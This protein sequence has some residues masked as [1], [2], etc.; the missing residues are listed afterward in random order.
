MESMRTL[1]RALDI[2]E[3][4]TAENNHKQGLASLVKATELPKATVHRMVKNLERRGYLAYDKESETYRLGYRVLLLSTAYL[5]NLEIRSVALPYMKELRDQ[6]SESVS[7]WIEKNDL[8]VCVER[9]QSEEPLRQV[10]YVGDTFPLG[11]GASGKLLLAY[12]N[13]PVDDAKLPP[14]E[15]E[16]IRSR[17]FSYSDSERSRGISA[18]AAPI[19]SSSG[20][21][22]AC[23]SLSGPSSRFDNANASAFSQLVIKYAQLVSRD[24]GF[25]KKES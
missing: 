19:Y 22:I 5:H 14:N 18:V 3:C 23:L 10:L 24:L 4:F 1:E 8:R 17:G 6:T 15:A 16:L 2:L 21:V 11:K 25:V 13:N 12:R 9:V 20:T 7:L